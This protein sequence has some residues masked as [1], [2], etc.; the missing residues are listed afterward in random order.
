LELSPSHVTVHEWTVL[1]RGERRLV[2]RISCSGG[3]YV[4]ALARDLGR[5]AGSAAHLSALRRLRSG[6]FGVADAVAFEVLQ[7]GD[8]SP[9]DVRT[10]IPGLPTQDVAEDE[11]R[12]VLHGNTIAARVDA[13][14]V[15]LI[16]PNG[17]LVALAARDGTFLQP[18]V[19]LRDS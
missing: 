3:T 12:R 2:V 4:R 7:T 18:R 15:A 13:P 6:T 1:Q 9:L 8:A 11:I 14:T 17:S 19:V 5:L 16:E 10:A